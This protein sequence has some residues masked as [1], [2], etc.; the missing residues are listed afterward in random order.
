VASDQISVGEDGVDQCKIPD[1]R[2]LDIFVRITSVLFMGVCG[3]GGV[4]GLPVKTLS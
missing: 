1:V 2:Y 3:C 4:Y